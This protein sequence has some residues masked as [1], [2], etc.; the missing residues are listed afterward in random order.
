MSAATTKATSLRRPMSASP[1]PPTSDA[2]PITT[3]AR[4][5]AT[6]AI[7]KARRSMVLPVIKTYPGDL[8]F[9]AIDEAFAPTADLDGVAARLARFDAHAAAARRVAVYH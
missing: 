1:R 2:I 3:P 7:A 5:R 8:G 4:A 6:R 9:D